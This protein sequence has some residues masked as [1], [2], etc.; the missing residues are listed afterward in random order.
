MLELKLGR[1]ICLRSCT[2]MLTQCKQFR[3]CNIYIYIYIYMCVCVCV[4]NVLIFMLQNFMS[5]KKEE[6]VSHT[7]K[8]NVQ[9][10]VRRDKFL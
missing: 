2:I 4:N 8:F 9:V 10:T 6:K 7:M 1:K 5:W 3:K